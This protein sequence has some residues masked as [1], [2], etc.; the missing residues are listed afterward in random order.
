[1][2]GSSSKE[3]RGSG[4]GEGLFE[5]LIQ[6]LANKHSELNLNFQ[7][8]SVG[9]PNLHASVEL[10]GTITV[11]IHMREMTDDEKQA[12]AQRNISMA[13]LPSL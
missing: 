9:I 12:L 1:L 11:S 13:S 10:N 3:S 2:T 8:T 5:G 4:F 7:H 6:A